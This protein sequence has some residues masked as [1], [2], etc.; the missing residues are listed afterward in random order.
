MVSLIIYISRE[1]NLARKTR[2]N[3]LESQITQEQAEFEREQFLNVRQIAEIKINERAFLTYHTCV[4]WSCS[5][6]FL[7]TEMSS[8]IY[9][10]ET[11]KHVLMLI[12]CLWSLKNGMVELQL[13]EEKE[14]RYADETVLFAK[15]LTD[16]TSSNQQGQLLLK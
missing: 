10:M 5:A 11:P 6:A 16:K 7:K 15:H 13:V 12:Q 14:T 1:S 8:V 3:F 2:K 9:E 4:S